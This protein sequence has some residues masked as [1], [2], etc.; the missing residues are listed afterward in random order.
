MVGGALRYRAIDI[1]PSLLNTVVKRGEYLSMAAAH[2]KEP[3]LRMFNP[4]RKVV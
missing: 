4:S 1:L 3:Q 2:E